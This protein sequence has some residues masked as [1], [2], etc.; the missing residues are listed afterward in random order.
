M[1]AEKLFGDVAGRARESVV[2]L[3]VGNVVDPV[4]PGPG[5]G[6]QRLLDLAARGDVLDSCLFTAP[7][8]YGGGG[9]GTTW[10]VGSADD[11]AAALRRYGELGITHFVLFDTPYK[12][13]PA[14]VSEALITRRAPDAGPLVLSPVRRG[15]APAS[16]A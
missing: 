16:G 3:F 14:R 2:H 1:R 11:V 5:V 9:A 12:R 10:L 4:V 7:G 6:Q 13:E 15:A 8:R